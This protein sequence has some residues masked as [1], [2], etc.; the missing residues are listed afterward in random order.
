M[1]TA[2]KVADAADVP[3]WILSETAAYVARKEFAVRREL[4]DLRGWVVLL[5]LVPDRERPRVPVLEI[6]GR[7]YS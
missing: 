1:S 2:G 4:E 6:D 3:A 7:I 5:G